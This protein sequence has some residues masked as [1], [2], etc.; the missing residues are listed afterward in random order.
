MK[1]SIL[2]VLAL[3]LIM[4][5]LVQAGVEPS[6]F[7]DFIPETKKLY[8]FNNQLLRIGARLDRKLN[9]YISNQTAPRGQ[10][11][12]VYSILNMDKKLVKI[13]KKQTAVV[14]DILSFCD[15]VLGCRKDDSQSVADALLAI[16][17]SADA[18]IE[19]NQYILNTFPDDAIPQEIISAVSQILQTAQ[20][21]SDNARIYCGMLSFPQITTYCHG[22]FNRIIIE[23][24]ENSVA[25]K[26]VF[27]ILDPILYPAT[28]TR[29]GDTLTLNASI[30]GFDLTYQFTFLNNDQNIIGQ[31]YADAGGQIFILNEWGV[32]GPCPTVD[33]ESDGV[34]QF[35]GNDFVD[36]YQID[37]ISLF[38]SAAGHDYSDGFE[39]CRSMKHYFSPELKINGTVKIFSP[40]DGTV[41][42]LY[43][44]EENFIDDGRTNQRIVI[45]PDNQPALL[46]ILF[47][48]DLFDPL[49]IAGTHLSAGQH[50]G[51]ARM[52]NNENH[53]SHN[54]DI[55]LDANTDA[56]IR[57][58]SYFDAMTYTL[59]SNYTAWD[60]GQALWNGFIISEDERDANPLTCDNGAFTSYGSLPSWYYD[61]P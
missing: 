61:L 25:Y 38:R 39:T 57:F 28:G 59:Y 54:F 8:S 47:H 37:N 52:I 55:A 31:I 26:V 20:Q 9:R 1:Q 27:A 4:T 30:Q 22:E 44:E 15:P 41:V 42:N 17:A 60:S 3:T 34:P 50:I 13:D 23:S 46:I 58:V 43:T 32:K 45:Q 6:P 16:G 35:I 12:L 29:N 2:T 5:P 48:V 33:I 21:V 40:V 7:N 24:R 56:G 14:T 36:L 49:P 51:Y 10:I 18:I 19:S 11:G 53:A